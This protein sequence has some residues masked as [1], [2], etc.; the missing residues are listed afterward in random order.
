[1]TSSSFLSYQDELK[2][3]WRDNLAV[4]KSL[5]LFQEEYDDGDGNGGTNIIAKIPEWNS[6]I[7]CKTRNKLRGP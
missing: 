1:L 3:I 6:S 4:T 2:Q 5:V 7:Y